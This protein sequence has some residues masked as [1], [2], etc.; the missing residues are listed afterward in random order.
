MSLLGKKKYEL[1]F[2]LGR[3]DPVSESN[4]PIKK[5]PGAPTPLTPQNLLHI[6]DHFIEP[7]FLV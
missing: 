1:D 2:D 5:D 7:L 3:Q 6:I 4:R